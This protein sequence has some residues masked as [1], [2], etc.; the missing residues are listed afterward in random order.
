MTNLEYLRGRLL[1]G[2]DEPLP[3]LSSL[4]GS[5]WSDT[6][7]RLMRNRLLIGAFRYGKL[8]AEGKPSYNRC[9][10][11]RQRIDLH[12]ESGNTEHLVDIANLCMLE[13]CEGTHSGRCFIPSDDG[14]HTK[15][16]K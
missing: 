11:I 16:L 7:E 3:D 6:F 1:A 13:F 5:E 2:I 15:P 4:R 12:Q 10:D 9:D 8:G 14:I